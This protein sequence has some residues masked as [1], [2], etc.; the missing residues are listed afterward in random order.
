MAKAK[1]L[2]SGQWRT[3]VYDYTDSDKK[4]HYESFT[5]DTKK[6]SEFLAAEFALSKKKK[7]KH[8]EPSITL[9]EAMLQYC[10]IKSNV[11]SPSTLH[12]Y[13]QLMNN[14][15]KS[16]ADLK[17]TDI[18]K[19]VLQKWVNDYSKTRSPKTTSNAY[20]FLTAVIYYFLEDITFK[21]T[22]PKKRKYD[23]YV[24]ND[25]EVEIL[26]NHY[27]NTDQDMLIASCLAAFGTMRR[28]EICGLHSKNVDGCTIHVRC[29]MVINESKKF[30]LKDYAK[31]YSSARDISM[32]Q[33][34]V[35]L[36]P[37]NGM[38]ININP[39]QVTQR[40]VRALDKLNINRFRFH[41]LRHYA[42]SI[43]HAL[44]IPDQYI[45]QRGGWSSDKVLKDIYRGTIDDYSKKFED[46]MMQHYDKMQHEMQ[47]KK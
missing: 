20:G 44:G 16:L 45:M 26:I 19:T 41:D 29:A 9:K 24:P 27:R 38:V 1:K 39:T 23:S 18:N 31:N 25:S 4:R 12:G 6:E 40:H 46:V 11:L 28:S 17:L 8:K 22:L 32:P 5:A 30:I 43:M 35:D 7:N 37:K 14:A 34:V 33:F 36:L 15:Y 42:A 10:D 3:L 21:T 47:H 13:K 2:P